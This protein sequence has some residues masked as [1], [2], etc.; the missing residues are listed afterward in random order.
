MFL[1]NQDMVELVAWRRRLH[2]MPE[3][4]GQERETAATVSALVAATGADRVITGLGG[5]GVAAVYDGAEP[6]PTVMV[7]AELDG[8]PI[9]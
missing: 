7:R 3:L 5:H 6:G 1:S 2:R 9:A 8:L 4:S